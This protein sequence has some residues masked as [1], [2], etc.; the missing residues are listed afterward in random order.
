MAIIRAQPRKTGIDV[1]DAIPWGSHICLFY[2]TPRDLINTLV[3][4]FKAGLENNELCIWAFPDV[5]NEEQRNRILTRALP[6]FAGY[7]A[8]GQI[9]IIPAADLY[10]SDGSFDAEEVLSG[11]TDKLEE[12]T[13]KGYAGMRVAGDT[14]WVGKR[15]RRK[16]ADYEVAVNDDISGR[17]IIAVCSYDIGRYSASEVLDISLHHQFTLFKR[18]G[19][20]LLLKLVPGKSPPPPRRRGN[21][22]VQASKVVPR[23]W[24]R[25]HERRRYYRAGHGAMP[26]CERSPRTGA[27]GDQRVP[28][29]NALYVC[30]S[31]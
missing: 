30:F 24:I 21:K 11:W 2:E 6:G 23:F 20:R 1:L 18:A 26:S 14:G 7:R 16:L 4:F 31:S 19:S 13:A 8:K 29:L 22:P 15:D 27:N 25:R 12:M 5:F 3:P 28:E 17:N 9:E 10:L